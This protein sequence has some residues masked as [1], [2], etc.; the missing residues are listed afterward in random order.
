VRE[1]T[2]QAERERKGEK[3]CRLREN[4]GD[5]SSCTISTLRENRGD[6][7]LS[8]LRREEVHCKLMNR[9][10]VSWELSYVIEAERPLLIGGEELSK[11]AG[12]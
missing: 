5:N 8:R 4:R 11:L 2:L 1:L 6:N 10:E 9:G 7:S 3:I 12:E